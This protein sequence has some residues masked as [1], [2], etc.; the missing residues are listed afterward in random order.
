[1]SYL[2]EFPPL[3][4]AI[5]TG[6]VDYLRQMAKTPQGFL[7]VVKGGMSA[8][9]EVLVTVS[10]I[11]D[12]HKLVKEGLF[13]LRPKVVDG[14]PL[15]IDINSSHLSLLADGEG[16]NKF[17]DSLGI[18]LSEVFNDTLKGRLN[19]KGYNL[20]DLLIKGSRTYNPMGLPHQVEQVKNM[21]NNGIPIRE[22]CVIVDATS[23]GE[24]NQ[25][26]SAAAQIIQKLPNIGIRFIV[27]TTPKTF[28]ELEKI[29]RQDAQSQVTSGQPPEWWESFCK[30]SI[31]HD[32]SVDALKT[33]VFQAEE[34]K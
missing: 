32:V 17:P 14:R 23:S 7:E 4:P 13:A 5:D 8:K 20:A 19:E 29:L 30:N 11:R 10:T 27:Q 3:H 21:N 34:G 22:V 25:I 33:V 12:T 2:A 1:M 28:K 16:L 31:N 6:N 9:G 26:L 15:M 18:I 24:N